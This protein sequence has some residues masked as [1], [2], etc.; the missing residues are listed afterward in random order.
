MRRI[1]LLAALVIA[2][3]LLAGYLFSIRVPTDTVVLVESDPPGAT[4]AI[5]G[6]GLHLVPPGGRRG[7]MV[8]YSTLPQTAEGEAILTPAAG[9]EIATRFTVTA[10]LD[11]VRAGEL[12][13][14]IGG[15]T[16][17]EFLSAQTDLMLR[18]YAARADA[19]EV[20]TPQF[21]KRAAESIAAALQKGGFTEAAIQIKPPDED[22][23]LAAAQYLAPRREAWK[24]RQAV[25]EALIEPGATGSWKLLTAM[26]LINGSDKMFTE[27]EKN[28]LDALAIEP[29]ALPPM[30]ELVAM[31]SAVKDWTKLERILDAALA[32]NPKSLQHINWT[33][34]VL[35][36]ME[37]YVGAERILK[38]GLEIE[39]DNATLL[40]NLGTLYM[41]MNRVNEAVDVFKKAADTAPSNQQALFNYGSALAATGRFAEAL[42]F[43][44]RAE[45]AGSPTLPLLATLAMVNEKAGNREKAADYRRRAK[46]M[47]ARQPARPQAAGASPR[48]T[49]S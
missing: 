8:S 26:G 41:K 37:D 46:E 31:Y 30:N 27:A 43:L 10:R 34:V 18:E 47:E 35:L 3:L 49:P 38:S 6:P 11:P 17:A 32:A 2:I 5:L 14:A 48:K 33:A 40:S 1:V 45:G 25:A 42:P 19:V 13:A 4:P 28:F 15:R 21:R 12:H 36:K 20:L 9:G 44:E 23:L 7:K 24:I 29:A 16:P 22:T 39:P